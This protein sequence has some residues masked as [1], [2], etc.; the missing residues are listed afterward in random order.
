MRSCA[1]AE[2][3]DERMALKILT[4]AED[5]SDGSE[6]INLSAWII[7]AEL[8][9]LEIA[10]PDVPE[11]DGIAVVL[12]RDGK[13]VC[14]CFVRGASLMGCGPYQ[15][16]VVVDKDIIVE[17]GKPGRA[18]QLAFVIEARPSEYDVKRL[19]FA[20]WAAGIDHGWV[21]GVKGGC[22][23][24]GVCFVVVAVEHLDLVDVHQKYTAVPSALAF[25]FDNDRGCPFDMKLAVS[26]VLF[27]S[28]SAGLGDNFHVSVFDLPTGRFPFS[29]C[30]LGEILAIEKNDG[31]RGC[32]HR[33]ACRTG[34][35]NRRHRPLR[36]MN[37]PFFDF[38]FSGLSVRVDSSQKN[39]DRKQ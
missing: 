31:I 29:I 18:D 36:I 35:D 9:F 14:M 6:P 32:G 21:L 34:I 12:Q 33:F 5:I 30:P 24:V 26:E 10:D 4:V 39:Q 23:A 38:L 3:G 19:P 2:K 16:R 27:G 7:R 1:A 17:D 8:F 28:D 37:L 11:A 15:L 22:H 25:A 20:G 13:P